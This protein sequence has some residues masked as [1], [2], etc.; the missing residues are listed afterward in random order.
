M[1]LSIM[2]PTFGRPKEF[3]RLFNRIKG[4]VH[5]EVEIVIACSSPEYMPQYSELPRKGYHITCLNTKGLT[6]EQ[7]YMKGL[8]H[9]KGEYTLI[10]EDDD[11]VNEQTIIDF[12]WTYSSENADLYVYSIMT[13]NKSYILKSVEYYTADDFLSMFYK[14]YGN[15]FQWGQCF[16]KTNLLKRAMYRLWVEDKELDLIQSDELITLMIAKGAK[17]VATFDHPLLWVG[18]G[19]DNYSWGN[20]KEEEQ[21]ERFRQ[22]RKKYVGDKYF[23]DIP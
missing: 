6:R 16:T 10:V 18:R 22:L 9:C 19:N 13:A 12:V 15:T 14:R 5:N 7:N 21:L 20:P 11:L 3:K 2:I 23:N 8:A 1:K 4:I 17:T